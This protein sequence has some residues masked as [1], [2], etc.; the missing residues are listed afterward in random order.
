MPPQTTEGFWLVLL[1]AATSGSLA[2]Q[3]QGS[4]TTEGQADVSGLGYHLVTYL[5]AVKNWPHLSPAHHGRAGPT[6]MRTGGAALLLGSCRK[7]ALPIAG[8][9]GKSALRM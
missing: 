8:A 3:Q 9:E 4:L 6:G 7:G 5:R 1:P 2:L